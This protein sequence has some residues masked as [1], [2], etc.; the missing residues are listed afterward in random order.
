VVQLLLLHENCILVTVLVSL[1]LNVNV[2][3]ALVVYVAQALILIVH[4]GK[5]VSLIVDIVLDT[6]LALPAVSVASH[7]E[8]YDVTV[9]CPDG[10]T[11]HLYTVLLTAVKLLMLALVTLTSQPVKF[12]VASLKVQVTMKLA[13]EK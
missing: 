2:V 7:A 6:V 1:A 5:V 8:T 10:V 4:V 3:H 13:P 11:V 12:V 9:H